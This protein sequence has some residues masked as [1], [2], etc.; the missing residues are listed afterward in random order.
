ML[1]ALD[2]S[3]VCARRSAMLRVISNLESLYRY[4][5]TLSVSSFSVPALR[6]T[7]RAH[8]CTDCSIIWSASL[9]PNPISHNYYFILRPALSPAPWQNRLLQTPPF[10]THLHICRIGLDT[11]NLRQPG[12]FGS[13][14]LHLPPPVSDPILEPLFLELQEA[15]RYVVHTPRRR[16]GRP[17]ARPARVDRSG[18]IRRRSH[19][20]FSACALGVCQF[21]TIIH[22]III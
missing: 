8:E 18:S 11:H 15:A 20:G 19:D 7:R 5:S 2:H 10:P 12:H 21:Q 14:R 17:A 13:A 6:M 22:L 3:D 16:P 1:I 9:L 4:R